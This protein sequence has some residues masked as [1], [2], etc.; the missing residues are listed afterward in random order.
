MKLF[1]EIKLIIEECLQNSQCKFTSKSVRG[2][3][4]PLTLNTSYHILKASLLRI[5]N[6]FMADT[7]LGFSRP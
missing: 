1:I 4:H 5:I 7:R 2:L 3:T 6:I